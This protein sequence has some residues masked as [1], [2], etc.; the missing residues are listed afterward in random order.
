MIFYL[1]SKNFR[2]TINS[3][4]TYS[5][6]TTEFLPLYQADV[7]FVLFFY[8]HYFYCLRILST[9]VYYFSYYLFFLKYPGLPVF[10]YP[11]KFSVFVNSNLDFSILFYF[12]SLELKLNLLLYND[13]FGL[14][15][16]VLQ[17]TRKIYLF[18]F[19]VEYFFHVPYGSNPLPKFQI[20][21]FLWHR[22]SVTT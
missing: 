1:V 18:R 19:Y 7:Y 14:I 5:V 21:I 17:D 3:K 20:G 8:L 6:W 15:S 16:S 9:Y 10:L 12:L 11:S 2:R 13:T 22:W 4:S